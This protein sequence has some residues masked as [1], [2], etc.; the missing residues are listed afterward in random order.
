[1]R[2]KPRMMADDDGVER[3]TDEQVYDRLHEALLFLG[4]I[5]A[6]TDL[7]YETLKRG[8]Y[9]MEALQKAMLKAMEEEAIG[10]PP[11]P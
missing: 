11:L 6:Q 4:A 7:G 1:M 10:K 5:P 8:I 9:F 3:L 2:D